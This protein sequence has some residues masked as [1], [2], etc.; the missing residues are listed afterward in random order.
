MQIPVPVFAFLP[1]SPDKEEK[2]TKLLSD[3]LLKHNVGNDVRL[4]GIVP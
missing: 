3:E 2:A 4:G 1:L